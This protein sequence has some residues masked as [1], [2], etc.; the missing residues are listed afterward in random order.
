MSAHSSI[1]KNYFYFSGFLVNGKF[2]HKGVLENLL[3]LNKSDFKLAH[4]ITENHINVPQAKK[5]NVRFAAQLLSNTVA[6]AILFCGE[7]FEIDYTYWKEVCNY[8]TLNYVLAY[9][10][11]YYFCFVNNFF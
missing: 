10:I 3:K 4:K 11:S 2:I 6:K 1:I 5:Q 8:L 7:N 9:Y